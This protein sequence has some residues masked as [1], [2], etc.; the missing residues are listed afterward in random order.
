MPSKETEDWFEKEQLHIAAD[1]GDLIRVKKLVEEGREVN[2]FDST[3]SFTPLHYAAKGERIEIVKYLLSVGADVN[4]HEE[5]KIGET[6]L[7]AVAENCSYE[8]AE[9]LVKAGANPIIPGWM[10]I[11]ALDRAG[12]RKRDEGRR[13]YELLHEVA[14]KKFHYKA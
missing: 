13:V 6:P 4:A 1:E 12:E 14:K 5:D 11:T 7:G 10:Q 8:L 9:L 2:A 3:L